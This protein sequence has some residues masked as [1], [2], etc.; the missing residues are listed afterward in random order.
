MKIA[1][2]LI[3]IVSVCLL[4]AHPHVFI[5][6]SFDIKIGSQGIE[7]VMMT[8][9][10]DEIFS[11]TILLD[12]DKNQNRMIDADEVKQIYSTAF[13]NTKN[14]NY[15]LDVRLAGKQ[16][17]IDSVYD[18]NAYMKENNLCYQFNF[19]LP[20]ASKSIS[21]QIVMMSYDPS[22]YIMVETSPVHGLKI[23]NDSSLVVIADVKEQDVDFNDY[24]VLPV[25]AVELFILP[26]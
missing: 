23:S 9:E 8:W 15:F 11:E 12:Y 25:N 19:K 5:E 10:F 6:S 3:W 18:F 22:Y 1:L 2:S 21:H 7:N 24:G 17:I 4:C 26:E 13:V 14:Y 20:D 16:V